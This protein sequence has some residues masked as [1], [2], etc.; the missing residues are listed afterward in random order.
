MGSQ[1]GIRYNVDNSQLLGYIEVEDDAD[2]LD[3][4]ILS[5]PN[6]ADGH[7]IFFFFTKN[8]NKGLDKNNVLL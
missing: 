7:R 3:Q 6:M 8:R 5:M 2:I 1:L 4:A